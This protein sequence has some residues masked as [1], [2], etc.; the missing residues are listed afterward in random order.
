MDYLLHHLL[1][2]SAE[3]Y[4]DRIAVEDRDR[5]ITYRD[6]AARSNQLAN[7]L[8]AR[9]VRRGDRVGFY[10]DKSMESV[11]AI[12]GIMSTGAAYVPFDPRAPISRLA[13]IARNAGMT[14]LVSGVEKAGQWEALVAE[15]AP[16][17][18]L[19][20]LNADTVPEGAPSSVASWAGSDVDGFPTVVPDV[21]QVH[22]DL[23]YILYTSGST[24]DPKGV[25]LSHLNA[26]TFVDWTVD[27]FGVTTEDRLS[28][29]APLH[30]DLSVFDLYAAA[31]V[32]AT[33]VLVPPETSV[34]PREVVR[35]IESKRISVWYSVP[36]ILSMLTMRGGLKPGDLP[37]LR[38]LLFA[39]EVFPTKYLRQL[40]GLLPRVR[41][42]NLYGPTE[43]NVCTWYEVPQLEPE[44]DEP[45]PIGKGIPN[46][47]C[48]VVGEDGTLV[49]PGEVGELWV[50]GSTVMQGYWGDAER[51]AKGLI[52]NPF[53]GPL[54]DR[55][56]KTGDLVQ[57]DADGN[58][59]FLGR[60]DNQIKSRGYRIE[61]GDVETA[62]YAHPDVVECAVVA[63]PDE[64]VTNRLKAFVVVRNGLSR[65][66]LIH[67]LGERIPPYMVPDMV[68]FRDALPKTST[69][70]IERRALS[71]LSG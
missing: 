46:V 42:A 55:I 58:Y 41:F 5:S 25:M 6:L 53:G 12:Y 17:E 45:I 49:R 50:R 67:F 26:L 35:F 4:P 7:L 18:H 11:I 61:L 16:I 37:T 10:L 22:H 27:E 28:G 68:E 40:M 31:A 64:L 15:G 19:V 32:G 14:H 56:Y 66:D 70:K 47:E 60:R 36:S 9:G 34:F 3:R 71:A 38:T 52:A 20:V 44:R 57:E 62:I 63:V 30:F 43:T 33:V 54:T 21:A 29:H 39:G 1:R 13:Y 8:I 65:S 23:A 2:S 48:Y 59:R 69:G 24:G 51:T